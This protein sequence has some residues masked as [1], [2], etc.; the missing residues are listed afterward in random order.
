MPPA[1]VKWVLFY[2][3]LVLLSVVLTYFTPMKD[4]VYFL[5]L[6]PGP[7]PEGMMIAGKMAGGVEISVQGPAGAVDA[8]FKTEPRYQLDLKGLNAGLTSVRIQREGFPVPGEIEILGIEPDRVTVRLEEKA[9][10]AVPVVVRFSG[11]PAADFI[12]SYT[13]VEPATVELV[14]P[15]S[16]VA[17]MTSAATKAVDIEGLSDSVKKEVVLD[18]PEYVTLSG[19]KRPLNAE[20]TIAEEIITR[21]LEKVPVFGRRTGRTF[22]IIPAQARI[23]ISGP[24]RTVESVSPGEGIEVFVDLSDLS[25]GVY[26]RRATITLPVNV[27]LVGVTPEIFTAKILP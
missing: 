9:T 21:T 12:V 11:K 4:A 3:L 17:P 20:I 2:G 5:P 23:V 18:L 24:A 15:K 10:R 13:R 8:W 16:V 27:T 1:R 6:D 19:E 22:E 25:P 7:P 26:V 14:G